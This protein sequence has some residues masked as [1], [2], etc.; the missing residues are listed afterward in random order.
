MEIANRSKT[1]NR[2]RTVIECT[3]CQCRTRSTTHIGGMT[4]VYRKEPWCLRT[5]A[6]LRT[7]LRYRLEEERRMGLM[8]WTWNDE[9]KKER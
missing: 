2:V 3:L 4:L 8:A 7:S 9:Y 5:H 6:R 1:N